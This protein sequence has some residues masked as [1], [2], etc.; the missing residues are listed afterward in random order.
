MQRS[1]P[2]KINSACEVTATGKIVRMD[3]SGA[4]WMRIVF[5]VQKVYKDSFSYKYGDKWLL[6][7][8]D[9]VNDIF[10][11]AGS[12]ICIKGII[13][14]HS[15]SGNPNA[16]DYGA[17]LL[18]EGISGQM[19]VENADIVVLDDVSNAGLMDYAERIRGFC[20]GIFNK[21]GISGVSL[22]I[23]NALVL[24]ERKGIDYELKDS[25]IHSGAIH[26]LAVS[27][28]HVG[29]IY[30]IINF[31]L[32]LFFSS[33][34]GI[35]TAIVIFLM[36]VY[37]I[38]TGFSPSVGRA[39][40]MFAFMQI[41][42][43]TG[44]D[45]NVYNILC[46]SAFVLLLYDPFFLFSAGFWLSHLAV[47]GI[48]SFTSPIEGMVKTSISFV[49]KVWTIVSVSIAAQLGVLPV[50]LFLFG[51]IPTYSLITNVLVLPLIAP[52]I[53]LGLSLLALSWVPFLSDI[54]V[55]V[56]D[57]LLKTIEFLVVKI[58]SIP[59]SYID[60]IWVSV[61]LLIA[62]YFLIIA[63]YNLSEYITGKKIIILASALMFTFLIIDIQYFIKR[64]D[65]MVVF[66]A[67]NKTLIEM[68]NKGVSTTFSSSDLNKRNKD[69]IA[70]AFERKNVVKT[71]NYIIL[72]DTIDSPFPLAYQTTINNKNI[73]LMSG[74][75]KDVVIN[76]SVSPIDF[77]IVIGK[78]DMNIKTIIEKIN[79]KTVIFSS[80]CPPWFVARWL[81]ELDGI[82]INT[83]NVREDGAFVANL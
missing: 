30:F 73:L 71:G 55:W 81:Q 79:C 80:N 51:A 66:N 63:I 13:S 54:L 38:I 77:L 35:R 25:F 15:Q 24:G 75:K 59:Y 23:L 67:G 61:P 29:I 41:G 62:L 45:V 20:S 9:D 82:D 28:L 46:V 36:S 32:N 83:H 3:K 50:I 48:V 5:E 68:V 1:F 56:T 17:Y 31:V 58:D 26:V 40:V 47:A 42:K 18:R 57:K 44:K 7:L 4:E 74:G 2:T 6:L 10:F 78:T 21:S 14:G 49:K 27:G 12:L 65:K 70:A 43:T 33:S 69:F 11:K 39:V 19:F 76:E 64:S 22:G 72:H 37:G 34:S 8:R 60:G 52:V 16:F 53:I